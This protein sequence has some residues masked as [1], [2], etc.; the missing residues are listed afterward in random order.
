MQAG[1]HYCIVGLGKTG[2]A[3]ANYFLAQSCRLTIIEENPANP[4]LQQF[5]TNPAVNC[6]VELPAHELLETMNAVVVSPGV[7]LSKPMFAHFTKLGIPIMGDIDIFAE[8]FSGKII[9]ITGSNG[10]STVTA[11]LGEVLNAAGKKAIVAGNIGT[12]VLELLD[13]PADYAVLEL[14]SYQLEI[15]QAMAPTIA[16]ILNIS[17]DHLDRYPSF[18][19]Y[20]AAKQRIYNHCAMAITNADDERT[21]PQKHSMEQSRF[22]I[23]P[24][25]V[26]DYG[27]IE[28]NSEVF[29]A[30]GQETL[31][32]VSSLKIKGKHN[33][34]NALAVF[35]MS[36]ALG[37]EW[38][39][40]VQGMMAFTGLA[41]RC[42]WVATIN[43]VDWIN[44]SKG[45]NV[46]ATV[47]ALEGIGSQIKG[48]IILLAGGQGKDADFKCLQSAVSQYCRHV[49]VFGEDKQ[50]L[51][52]ALQ[53]DV[54]MTVG[55]NFDEMISIAI[56]TAQ[57]G[58]VVLLSPACASFDMFENFIERGDVFC[59]KVKEL[60]A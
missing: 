54:S 12:P 2:V 53:Q 49:I 40:I 31:M 57:V 52:Q 4:N 35:A 26:C 19:A 60:T 7:P 36:D 8:Q 47:A 58:D 55:N 56:T 46:G 42:Q 43:D 15:T 27:L 25:T 20:V 10:K 50:L 30:R 21:W 39:A 16:A 6:Y 23:A 17:P 44:D 5:Q 3:C 29:L 28:E 13:T 48:K 38:E 9:A 24:D 37:I 1:E 51:Q 59:Q 14:S 18:D 45:T 41:H 34:A 32:S 11:L 33:W 22:A